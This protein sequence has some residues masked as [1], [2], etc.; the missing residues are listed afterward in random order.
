MKLF[1][2]AMTAGVFLAA[3]PSAGQSD[4]TYLPRLGPV[5][6]GAVSA[7]GA[8]AFSAAVLNGNTLYISG[9][10]DIDPAT[11]KPPA[12]PKIGA[13]LVLDSIKRTVE[14]AGMTM[15]DMVWV[16]VFA[17][18]LSNYAMFNDVYRPYFKGPV[19]A[20]AFI[21]AGSLLGNAHF[22]VMAI[23]VKPPRPDRAP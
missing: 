7:A 19:P 3:S 21:G 16:Q 22:E 4:R 12:D 15:D 20:R 1:S 13:K 11:G 23:A 18:D 9:A 2:I 10:T 17:T 6:P 14:R 8:P 5:A